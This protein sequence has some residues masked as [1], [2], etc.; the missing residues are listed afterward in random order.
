MVGLEQLRFLVRQKNSYPETN[1]AVFILVAEN[2]A[3]FWL[4]TTT[5]HLRKQ[6]SP[7]PAF[8]PSKGDLLRAGLWEP[9]TAGE[10]MAQ[11][12]PHPNSTN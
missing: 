5:I 4:E 3:R 11:G 10:C 8:L 9:F 6:L 12:P 1:S 2:N 7:S